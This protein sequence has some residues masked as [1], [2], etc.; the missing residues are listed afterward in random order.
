MATYKATI[1]ATDD[2]D[3][4][5]SGGI[6]YDNHSAVVDAGHGGDITVD[7]MFDTGDLATDHL[8]V[9]ADILQCCKIP[10]GARITSWYLDLPDID[11]ATTNTFDFGLATQDADA[12]LDGSTAGRSAAVAS[13]TN[14]PNGIV[15]GSVP[16][17]VTADDVLQLLAAAGGAGAGSGGI[18]K[19]SVTYN[20]RS[21][22]VF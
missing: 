19:G 2:G 18:I 5:I 21:V 15:A 12:F 14:N 10:K 1:G 6:P 20:M 13:P 11:S 4:T 9:T 3:G 8:F 17:T 7:F 16:L 22:G